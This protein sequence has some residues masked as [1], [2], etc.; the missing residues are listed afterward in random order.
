M[1]VLI[2]MGFNEIDPETLAAVF[3]ILNKMFFYC[4]S[5]IP[6]FFLISTHLHNP[7]LFFDS[8]TDFYS[9]KRLRSCVCTHYEQLPNTKNDT[10][11]TGYT[12]VSHETRVH[13]D[14]RAS[15]HGGFSFSLPS[16]HRPFKVTTP[17]FRRRV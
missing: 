12:L 7:V 13:A 9:G 5:F 17:I 3:C 8:F 10:H 2:K 6:V 4:E 14:R 15:V 11:R 16:L 1:S